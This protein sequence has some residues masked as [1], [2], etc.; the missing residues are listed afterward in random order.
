MSGCMNACGHHHVGH[1]G[2]L[3]VDK[4]GVEYYQLTVGGVAGDGARL[5]ERLGPAI[6][7]DAVADTIESLLNVYVQ[8]REGDERFIDTVA[9]VGVAPFK[10][11]AYAVAA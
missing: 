11:R 6:T 9:R 5:G 3:G 2:I 7:A 10:D 8:L 4:N 1:I